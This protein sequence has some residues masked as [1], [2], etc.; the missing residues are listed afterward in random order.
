MS[1]FHRISVYQGIYPE[2]LLAVQKGQ[3]TVLWGVVAS[4]E[5]AASSAKRISA[6]Q[7][8]AALKTKG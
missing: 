2:A 8:Q 6:D 7:L 1:A 4:K 5:S 3:C